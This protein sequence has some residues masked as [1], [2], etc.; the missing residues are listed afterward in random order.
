MLRLR[1]TCACRRRVLLWCCALVTAVVARGASC[2]GASV[3]VS[4][5]ECAAWQ[6]LYDATGG[7]RWRYCAVRDDP[8]ACVL[9][10]TADYPLGFHTCSNATAKTG[11]RR[12][13]QSLVLPLNNMVGTL[14]AALAQLTDVRR[15]ALQGNELAGPLPAGLDFI[16]AQSAGFCYLLAA[17]ASSNHFAC[18]LPAAALRHCS[19]VSND[20]AGMAVPLTADE[21]S[22]PADQTAHILYFVVGALALLFPCCICVRCRRQQGAGAGAGAGKGGGM[23]GREQALTAKE[24]RAIASERK[25]GHVL[26]KPLL[27]SI[28]ERGDESDIV[29]FGGSDGGSAAN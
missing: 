12:V 1:L 23:G 7:D 18:P 10:P 3:N 6:A 25:G 27:V 16:F 2:T 26:S 29:P 24:R 15:I 22:K 8:C 4:A 19:A 5:A 14:P 28:H 21:C 20:G 9:P 17:P 11:Y 13:V